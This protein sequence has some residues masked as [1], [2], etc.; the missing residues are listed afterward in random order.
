MSTKHGDTKWCCSLFSEF[1]LVDS[2][3]GVS[4]MVVV[5]DDRK[6]CFALQFRSVAECDRDLLVAKIGTFESPII[7]KWTKFIKFCPWCGR[8]LMRFYKHHVFKDVENIDSFI[9]RG[10]DPGRSGKVPEA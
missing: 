7:L 5:D 4:I 6:N 2:V 9:S 1:A 3:A 8:D 10:S